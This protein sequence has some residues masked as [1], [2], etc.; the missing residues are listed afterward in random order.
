MKMP[1]PLF[2]LSTSLLLA[3][4]LSAA[5]CV[6]GDRATRDASLEWRVQSLE[7]SFLDFQESHRQLQ[8]DVQTQGKTLAE[9]IQALEQR[10]AEM[11]AAEGGWSPGGDKPAPE[12]AASASAL[13]SAASAPETGVAAAVP[14]VQ[15]GPESAE[16]KP[17]D[18]TPGRPAPVAT[19]AKPAASANAAQVYAS[20]ADAGTLYA[21]ALDML[22]AG[23]A[24]EA[25]ALLDE[26]LRRYP[27]HSLA[28]NAMYW[29]GETWYTEKDYPKAILTFK[30]VTTK[31][32][33]HSKAAA[34][35]LKIGMSYRN[36]KDVDN[37]VFYLRTL[38]DEHPDSDPARQARVLLK[39]LAG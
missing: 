26:F 11:E 14:P 17:W 30:D 25:R 24:G 32:P 20:K 1:T 28:P 38:V 35:L 18:E 5:G 8:D 22:S 12:A 16:D 13:S 19:A 4:A 7:K 3:V 27:G 9:R 37:A 2:L 15:A 23:K 31:F 33:K 6:T 34:A 21:R 36:L 10:L 39:E 29:L